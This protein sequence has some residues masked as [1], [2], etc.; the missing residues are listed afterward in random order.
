MIWPW[1][2]TSPLRWQIIRSHPAVTVD[3][4]VQAAPWVPSGDL[5]V[6]WLDF[7]SLK[8][9]LLLLWLQILYPWCFIIHQLV[10]PITCCLSS[11]MANCLTSPASPVNTSQ[12]L[13]RCSS[14]PVRRIVSTS[15]GHLKSRPCGKATDGTGGSVAVKRSRIATPAWMVTAKNAATS[16]GY[17][18]KLW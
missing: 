2:L 8:S 12:P 7:P 10:F 14:D 11:W 5:Q 3:P 9:K 4:E 17:M 18:D 15:T 16:M 13:F 1:T 6:W